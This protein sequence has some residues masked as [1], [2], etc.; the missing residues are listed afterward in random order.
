MSHDRAAKVQIHTRCG[1]HDTELPFVDMSTPDMH[2]GMLLLL[3]L[4]LA[5]I[6]LSLVTIMLPLVTSDDAPDEP[7]ILGC[8]GS[9]GMVGFL[10]QCGLVG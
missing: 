5:T 8:V 1:P 7:Q 9:S 10:Q 2:R 6:M 4:S 3:M